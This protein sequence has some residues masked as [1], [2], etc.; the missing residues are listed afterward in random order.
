M[1]AGRQWQLEA[2]GILHCHWLAIEHHD[3]IGTTGTKGLAVENATGTLGVDAD[4]IFG[5]KREIVGDHHAATSAERQT[6]NML[7]LGAARCG[8]FDLGGNQRAIANSFTTNPH[9]S[10]DVRIDQRR[11]DAQHFREIVET[12][13]RFIGG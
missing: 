2:F 1:W 13:R 11:R 10:T 7:R 5:I 3:N 9:G 6:L 4:F 8:I 12:M